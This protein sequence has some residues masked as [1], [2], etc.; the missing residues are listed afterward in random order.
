VIQNGPALEIAI[1]PGWQ[2]GLGSEDCEYLAELMGDW[3]RTNSMEMPALLQALAELSIGPLRTIESGLIDSER[4]GVLVK[5]VCD[6][7]LD[8]DAAN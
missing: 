6:I 1:R 3:R 4:R 2:E 8:S 5:Q 7:P